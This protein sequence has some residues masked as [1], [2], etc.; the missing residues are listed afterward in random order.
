VRPHIELFFFIYPNP[1]SNV[2]NLEVFFDDGVNEQVA[3]AISHAQLVNTMGV[4]AKDFPNIISEHLVM[5][6]ADVSGGLYVARAKVGD[7][8]HTKTVQVSK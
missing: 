4:V 2:L 8:W 7:E 5:D 6:L 1:A 3:L